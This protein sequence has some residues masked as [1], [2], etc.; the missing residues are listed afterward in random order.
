MRIGLKLA[1]L[2]QAYLM[3]AALLIGGVPFY[4][5]LWP[6][7]T[8]PPMLQIATHVAMGVVLTSAILIFGLYAYF[9]S[10]K[11]DESVAE[12][13][14]AQDGEVVKQRA[15]YI[16][17]AGIAVVFLPIISLVTTISNPTG[18][19]F[20]LAPKVFGVAALAFVALGFLVM[21]LSKPIARKLTLH[22]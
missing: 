4:R 22:G 2:I 1:S 8:K 6:A 18:V 16:L 11:R 13:S 14:S 20:D 19:P 9:S 10:K 15:S 21:S 5:F 7:I 3:C 12:S 17:Y